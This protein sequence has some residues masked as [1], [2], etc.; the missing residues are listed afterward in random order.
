MIEAK[1]KKINE[2]ARQAMKE[3]GK[4]LS[5]ASVPMREFAER[6]RKHKQRHGGRR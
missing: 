1:I 4:A 2:N 3:I 5:V 6:L